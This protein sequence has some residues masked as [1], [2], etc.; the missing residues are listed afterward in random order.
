M[1]LEIIDFVRTGLACYLEQ[2]APKR[3]DCPMIPRPKT[4][5]HKRTSRR[6]KWR[7]PKVRYLKESEHRQTEKRTHCP[8]GKGLEPSF[9][10]GI[11]AAQRGKRQGMSDG[12]A[13]PVERRLN[14]LRQGIAQG[15]VVEVGVEVGQNRTLWSNTL[16]PVQ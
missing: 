13:K 5:T 4:Q 1:L 15:L 9:P 7:N 14:P 3:L 10:R 12:D 11:A 2:V 8:Q 16:N 6:N